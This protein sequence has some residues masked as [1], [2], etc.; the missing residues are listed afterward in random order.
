[1]TALK[2]EK[3]SG[4]VALITAIILSFILIITTA[5]LNQT[6]F[7]ARGMLLAS[8]Y[9]ER[10]AALAEACVDVARLKLVNNA[11]YG[12]NETI[13]IGSGDCD[14]RPIT[15]NIIETRA[16]Y[17]KAFTNLKVVVSSSSLSVISWDELVS[18]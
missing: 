18:F 9:K 15:A 3:D 8:E 14:I 13:S 2:I 7:L 1:M 10:S 17:Q 6:S 12:G 16:E 11:S 5:T 4:F